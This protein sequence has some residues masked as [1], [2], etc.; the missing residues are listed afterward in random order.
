M[1][2]IIIISLA[3][4]ALFIEN[5]AFAA[6]FEELDKP[7]EGVYKG[8]I[9]AGGY[10]SIGMAMGSII[11][12]EDKFVKGS[13][14]TFSDSE[15][16][17]ALWINHISYSVGIFGEYLPI[18]YV[19]VYA[20]L[21]YS[22]VIQLTNFGKDYSNTRGS[23]YDGYTFLVGPNLHL[24]NRKPWD[25]SLA[26]LVGFAYGTYNAT[27]VA[28]KLLTGYDPANSKSTA[29]GL[30]YGVELKLSLFFSG[31]F[32]LSLG[33]EWIRIPIKL[34]APVDATNSQTGARF[35]N[36]GTSGEIDNVRFLL[37]AG[38][39]FTN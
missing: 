3:A 21:G 7:P 8:Q 33:G 20:K 28:D 29:S 24:T 14:Y 18:D 10:M 26:P 1:V 13:T 5:A 39:A 37:C 38:Y 30:I 4:L 25:L 36:G 19:G 15:T 32:F 6:N 34:S 22:S 9:L 2:R 35:L 31:G 11:D 23:L 16:T 27:P 17:K 12:A